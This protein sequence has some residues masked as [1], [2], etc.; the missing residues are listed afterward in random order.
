MDGIDEIDGGRIVIHTIENW[1]MKLVIFTK[2]KKASFFKRKEN[3]TFV[4]NRIPIYQLWHIAR[5]QDPFYI[6]IQ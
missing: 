3:M 4:Q 1:I 6:I 2:F 5:G